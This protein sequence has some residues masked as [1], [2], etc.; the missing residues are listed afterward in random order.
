MKQNGLLYHHSWPAKGEVRISL[1]R[2]AKAVY[3]AVR[4][5]GSVLIVAGLAG[6]I[7]S[8]QPIIS[9]EARYAWYQAFGNPQ[10]EERIIAEAIRKARA[11]AE[12]QRRER[13]KKLAQDVGLE[14]TQ[15]SI[16]VPK[17]S[18]K[19]SVFENVSPADPKA[20]M[21]ALQK[22][23]AHAAGSVFPG[24]QGAAYLFAHSTDAPW[25]V[26]Q[27]NAVFYLLRELEE[28]DEV[29][30]FFLDDIYKYKVSRK[31][32]VESEDVTWLK[33]AKEGP[34]RLILQTCWPPGTSLKRLIVVAE[35]AKEKPSSGFGQ[36]IQN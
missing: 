10:E 7:L 17:I 27:F 31:H 36:L 22:G 30:V 19:A 26:A 33:D 6:F 14:N 21:Q 20:Y 34:E 2:T 32:I 16:Y 3:Y 8:Y 18:A 23:V 5:F 13:V 28:G 24:M 35:P 15:F 4:T 1:A 29:Y 11:Q 12:E 9:S 25:N